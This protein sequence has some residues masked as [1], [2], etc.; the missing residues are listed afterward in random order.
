[1]VESLI[2]RARRIK[3]NINRFKKHYY[4]L[5]NYIFVPLKKVK[6]EHGEINMLTYVSFSIHK[7]SA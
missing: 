4:L 5:T 6:E 2:R 1:M 3:I 7:V